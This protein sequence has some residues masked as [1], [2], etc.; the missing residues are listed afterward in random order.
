[1]DEVS[2]DERDLSMNI[3]I[4]DDEDEDA[5]TN[6]GGTGPVP[7]TSGTCSLRKTFARR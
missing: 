7:G 5:E 4:E 6:P 2:F 1:M 3:D